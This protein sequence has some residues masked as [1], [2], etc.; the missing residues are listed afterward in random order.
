MGLSRQR[1]DPGCGHRAQHGRLV[2]AAGTSVVAWRR[3]PGRAGVGHGGDR[4][5]ETLTMV[6]YTPVVR[7]QWSSVV[8][9]TTPLDVLFKISDKWLRERVLSRISTEQAA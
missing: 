8:E 7:I 2:P 5:L 1:A 9:L 3:R 6:T 4:A